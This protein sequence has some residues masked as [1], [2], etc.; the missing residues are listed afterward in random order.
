MEIIPNWWHN[1][2]PLTYY[3]IG[4][5]IK[6]FK[7]MINKKYLLITVVVVGIMSTIF[8]VTQM[9]GNTFNFIYHEDYNSIIIGFISVS[10]FLLLYNVNIKNKWCN[11]FFKKISS[12]TLSIYLFSYIIDL[13]YIEKFNILEP[14]FYSTLATIFIV[15]PI[16][17]GISLLLAYILDNLLKIPKLIKV[18]YTK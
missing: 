11:K 5:Y 14:S 18:K 6:E 4:N 2:Y 13:F 9:Q 10:I 17:F 3:F 7:P 16:I 1:I 8:K 15:A 12:L